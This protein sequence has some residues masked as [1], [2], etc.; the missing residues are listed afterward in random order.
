MRRVS[1]WQR[2]RTWVSGSQKSD[3]S[4]L[5]A[6]MELSATQRE[7]ADEL[8]G[9]LVSYQERLQDLAARLSMLD[10]EGI[11]AEGETIRS[12]QQSLQRAVRR[13]SVSERSTQELT[14]E[15]QDWARYAFQGP[16]ARTLADERQE[17]LRS[18]LALRGVHLEKEERDAD[19]VSQPCA[20]E[21]PAPFLAPL[22]P[23]PA[24]FVADD[25]PEWDEIIPS[26]I[27][28]E[29]DHWERTLAEYPLEFGDPIHL[30]DLITRRRAAHS[31]LVSLNRL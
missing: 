14:N 24:S 30:A 4:V 19:A 23:T 11:L 28:N 1:W 12:A 10:D 8:E 29:V 7:I 16:L 31:R 15:W 2:F 18:E 25:F 26:A 27:K 13:A 21:I 5:D 6:R 22:P 20:E 9:A 17:M 3:P